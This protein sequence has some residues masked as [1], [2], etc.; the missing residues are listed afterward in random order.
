MAQTVRIKRRLQGDPGAPA[1][2]LNAELAFNEIGGVLYYGRGLGPDDSATEIV[3]IGG[4]GAFVG[5]TGVQTIAGIKTFTD[6]VRFNGAVI[7]NTPDL[8]DSSQLVATTE[9]VKNQNYATLVNGFIPASQL[10]SFVDDIIEYGNITYLPTTGELGKI[11]MVTDTGRVYRWSG[12][13]YVEIVASPGT[14]DAIVEGAVNLFF[15]PARVFEY[16]PVKSV[17]GRTG[18]VY[19]TK[20]DVGLA[21]VDNT[22]D[23]DK[24]VSTAMQFALDAKAELTHEHA[25]G[26]VVNLPSTLTTLSQTIAQKVAVNDIID[27]GGF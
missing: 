19:V 2:L 5:L 9:F 23:L 11:Y 3:P 25:I 26:D 16:A 4:F 6:E 20:I 24:P 22:A 13:A 14:T 10:P 15:T 17:A 12:S 21:A 7:A 18:N 27:G 1:E 8:A